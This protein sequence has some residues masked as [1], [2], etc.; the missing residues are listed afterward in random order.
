MFVRFQFDSNNGGWPVATF[1]CDDKMSNE[2]SFF[3]TA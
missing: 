1:I 2:T 3:Y